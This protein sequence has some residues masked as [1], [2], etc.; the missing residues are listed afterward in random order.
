MRKNV[1][2]AAIL[3][4]SDEMCLCYVSFTIDSENLTGAAGLA[5]TSLETF[6]QFWELRTAAAAA[7]PRDR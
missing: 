2:P 6:E 3:A 5:P 7:P 1:L 4:A